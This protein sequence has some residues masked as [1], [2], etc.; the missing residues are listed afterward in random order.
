MLR[1]GNPFPGSRVDPDDARFPAL[2]RGFNQRWVGSPRWVQVVGDA[3]RSSSL[4]PRGA[5]ERGKD[6]KDLRDSKDA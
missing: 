3:Q 6:A 1:D 4:F 5:W 2:I